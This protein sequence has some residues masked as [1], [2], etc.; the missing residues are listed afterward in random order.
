MKISISNWEGADGALCLLGLRHIDVER[1][2]GEM[3]TA[4][5]AAKQKAEAAAAPLREEIAEIERAL[6]AWWKQAGGEVKG[7]SWKGLYGAIGQRAGKPSV[8]SLHGEKP[9]KLVSRIIAYS[10]ALA[11]K[12]L[13]RG[14]PHLNKE[15]ILAATPRQ[16]ALLRHCGV[17][18]VPGGDEF[19]AKPDLAAIRKHMEAA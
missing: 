6:D 18:I 17:T 3:N 2:D 9:E 10:R 4:I 16:L 12:F 14:D 11:N 1:I 7:K 8:S 19:F 13:R 15:A 5:A